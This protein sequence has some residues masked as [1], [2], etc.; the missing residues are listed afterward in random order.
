MENVS[1]LSGTA[2]RLSQHCLGHHADCN[3]TVHGQQGECLSTVRDSEEIFSAL[4]MTAGKMSQHCLGQ[5]GEC[6]STVRDS[7]EN[8]S[9][10]FGTATELKD[11]R[12]ENGIIGGRI[13]HNLR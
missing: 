12:M 2:C 5:R 13:V 11:D 1:A 3:T 9:A 4:S 6:L 10:L 8:V 7:G